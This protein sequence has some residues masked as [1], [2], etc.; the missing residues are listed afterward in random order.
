VFRDPVF[1]AE[2]RYFLSQEEAFDKAMEKSVQYIRRSKELNISQR[3]ERYYLS[4]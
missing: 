4:S 2:D 1:R 3:V